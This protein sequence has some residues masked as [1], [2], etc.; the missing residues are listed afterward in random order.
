M[1]I[2]FDE[3]VP[4]AI[5]KVFIALASER[6]FRKQT[7]GLEIH[8]AKEYAPA[9]GDP[10]YIKGN[11]VPWITRFARA[12][13]QGIIS[14][15]TKMRRLPH[16]RLALYQHNFVVIFFESQWD[17]WDFSQKSG[18]LLYWWPAV[19]KK[20]KTASPGTFWVIPCSLT[21]DLRNVSIGLAQ[22]LKD[23]PERQ[24]KAEPRKRTGRTAKRP[25]DRQASLPGVTG[26]DDRE[27]NE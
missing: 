8:T 1:K 23:N 11:D 25:D 9:K 27:E 14:G 17:N 12:G 5:A 19:V 20:L 24:K 7:Q 3:H 2:A 26:K 4:I 16:E 18:L 10:D 13:G 22:L 21:G 6:G 15:D